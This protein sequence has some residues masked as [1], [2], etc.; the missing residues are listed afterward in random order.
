M[1][2]SAIGI[3]LRNERID[4]IYVYEMQALALNALDVL[5]H[6]REAKVYE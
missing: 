4:H 5:H 1:G 2:R 3:A 6:R